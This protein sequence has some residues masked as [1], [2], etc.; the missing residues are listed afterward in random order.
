MV[1]LPAGN[2]RQTPWRIHPESVGMDVAGV[3]GLRAHF[4]ANKGGTTQERPL[5]A[6][7]IVTRR[8]PWRITK[9]RAGHKTYLAKK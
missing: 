4:C 1:K 5:W 9:S 3:N 8:K 2:V 7:F 6:L